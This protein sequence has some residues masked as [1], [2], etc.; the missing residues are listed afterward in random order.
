MIL[1]YIEMKDILEQAVPEAEDISVPGITE[2]VGNIC[3]TLH[4][5]FCHKRA[6]AVGRL[7]SSPNDSDR[8]Y[9]CDECIRACASILK[10]TEDPIHGNPLLEEFLNVTE[11]WL[12][13]GVQDTIEQ[14]S[15]MRRIASLMF[16]NSSEL[17]R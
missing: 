6:N 2:Q 13:R 11:Q 5:S 8:A 10:E 3:D 17:E 12:V 15:Q 7:I 14:L 9:I 4:C 16:A 1:Y